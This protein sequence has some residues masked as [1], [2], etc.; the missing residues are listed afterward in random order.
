M[1]LC[2]WK[3]AFS[4][5]FLRFSFALSCFCVLLRFRFFLRSRVNG[6][7]NRYISFSSLS[8]NITLFFIQNQNDILYTYFLRQSK[9]FLYIKE[10]F[11][12]CRLL[13][14]APIA[15][16]S[17]AS[18]FLCVF[19]FLRFRFLASWFSEICVLV[20]W[21]MR[22]RS[23]KYASSFFSKNE[24]DVNLAVVSTVALN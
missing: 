2:S 14:N 24:N 17:F 8:Y 4:F 18:S 22:F 15:M 16:R 13:Y 6:C 9:Y 21:N 12:T 7:R 19:V 10:L 23:L 1:R 11:M 3:Y 20:L 5:F